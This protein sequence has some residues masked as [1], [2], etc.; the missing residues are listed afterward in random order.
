MHT[1]LSINL[2]AKTERE[3]TLLF[4]STVGSCLHL[5]RIFSDNKLQKRTFCLNKLFRQ[6]F[7][8]IESDT[9]QY[10]K[11]KTKGEIER[12]PI[13]KQRHLF[14]KAETQV[15]TSGRLEPHA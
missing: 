1:A 11:N 7:Y 13:K 10:I 9:R 2:L 15:Q 6:R 8:K 3:K 12:I 5:I 4:A 14:E